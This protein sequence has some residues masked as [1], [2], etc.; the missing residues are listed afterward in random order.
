MIKKIKKLKRKK[1]F[2]PNVNRKR[3]RN[4]LQKL[5]IISCDPI[6]KA[7]TNTKSTR[8]NLKE[9]GLAYDA[10]EAVQIPNVKREMLE[11]AK[12]IVREDDSSSDHE[13]EDAIPIKSH[14]MENLE[15][16]TKAPR[17]RRFSLPKGEAQFLTYLIKKY[18]E[19]YKAMSRDKKN[20]YQLTW[21]QIRAKIK[22]FKGIPEQYNKY[23]QN[24][25]TKL[26]S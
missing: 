14:V 20:H 6:K 15:A 3:L 10:N 17:E 13:A 22:M 4:K 23:L 2:N 12:R 16:E 25:S 11:E 19:D 18:G 8:I 7:W 1:K 26:N 9:M 21:K 5:P 24:D